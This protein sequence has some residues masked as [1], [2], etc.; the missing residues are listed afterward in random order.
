MHHKTKAKIERLIDEAGFKTFDW[1]D[2]VIRVSGEEGDAAC[3][4]YGEG[5]G[6]YPWIN[7][8]LEQIAEANGCFWE[9]MN[10]GA[11]ALYKI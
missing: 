3:D 1:N 5:S 11:I 6:G 2:G 8:T 10:P 7:P 4:Y 9:W